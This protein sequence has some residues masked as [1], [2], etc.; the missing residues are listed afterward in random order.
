MSSS[1]DDVPLVKNKAHGGMSSS[2]ALPYSRI[3]TYCHPSSLS[4]LL[5]LI[6]LKRLHRLPSAHLHLRKTN[7][8]YQE[9]SESPWVRRML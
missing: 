4:L 1:D 6:E 3:A 9:N 5:P 2:L 8:A 7:K